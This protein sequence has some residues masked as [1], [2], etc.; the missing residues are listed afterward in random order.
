MIKDV[1]KT[2]FA[3]SFDARVDYS[4]PKCGSCVYYYQRS[5]EIE[6][7]HSKK[8]A[9]AIYHQFSCL[10][11]ISMTNP[12]GWQRC[13]RAIL[14]QERFFAGKTLASIAGSSVMLHMRVPRYCQFA[15][16]CSTTAIATS[17]IYC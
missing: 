5:N 9:M 12:S 16:S 4:Q 10:K 3:V 15:I 7:R 17:S 14:E 8:S 13:L 11:K 2:H 6:L 1:V